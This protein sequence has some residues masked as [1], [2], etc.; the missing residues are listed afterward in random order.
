[1]KLGNGYVIALGFLMLTAFGGR[2][3][4]ALL[5]RAFVLPRATSLSIPRCPEMFPL[6]G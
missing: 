5:L 2:A 3:N 6:N 1:M 4:F